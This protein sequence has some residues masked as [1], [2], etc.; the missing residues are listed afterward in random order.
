MKIEIKSPTAN[1]SIKNPN[2][3]VQGIIRIPINETTENISYAL[4]CYLI[5]EPNAKTEIV[6]FVFLPFLA[7]WTKTET[8]Y[9]K[10]FRLP[11][12]IRKS[13]KAI[14]VQLGGSTPEPF[15]A[16]DKVT[17]KRKYVKKQ[18]RHTEE[19]QNDGRTEN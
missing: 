8:E 14:V 15:F 19:N 4:R 13:T 6:K 1:T 3:N 7:A 11:I 2:V 16:S 18:P 5:N 12:R 9:V 17:F 10:T